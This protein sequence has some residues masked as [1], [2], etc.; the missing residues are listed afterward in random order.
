M[1]SVLKVAVAAFAAMAS[2]NLTAQSPVNFPV[3]KGETLDNKVITI[4]YTNGKYTIIGVAFNRDAEDL[5]KRWLQPMFETFIKDESG[6]GGF[7]VAD[8]HDVNFIF[9]PVIAGLST[10]E[11]EF[12]KG[13]DKQYW[14]YILDIQKSDAKELS[15]VLNAKDNKIPYFY[16]V[17]PNGKILEMVSGSYD[18]KKMDKLEDAV[19]K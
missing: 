10:V 16:A 5:L 9:I 13:T 12:K 11:D 18:A 14:P 1:K 6:G 8:Y 7:D 17:D 4:P 19:D 2:I 3:V 15:R